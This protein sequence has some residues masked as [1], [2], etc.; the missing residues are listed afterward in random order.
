MAMFE[1]AAFA[2]YRLPEVF[3]GYPRADSRFPIRYPTACS[4]QAWATA[5]PFL[6]LRVM[7]GIDAQDGE[8]VCDPVVPADVGS[9]R[10]HGLH[11]FGGH[12]DLDASGTTGTVSPTH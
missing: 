7:L 12:L 5:A 9:I 11:A 3:A 4:P 6:W 1:A 10:V 2:D 8:L